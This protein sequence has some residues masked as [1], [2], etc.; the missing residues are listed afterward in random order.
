MSAATKTKRKR[1]KF[2]SIGLDLSLT[3]S[4]VVVLVD[5]KVEYTSTITSKPNGDGYYGEIARLLD[6]VS[7]IS[8]V[9]YKYAPSIV[10]IEGIAFMAKNTTALVQLSALNYFLRRELFFSGIPFIIVAPPTL[11]KFATGK[12]NAT[13]VE[14][15]DSVEELYGEKFLDDNQA[16]AYVLARCA[17]LAA[18]GGS[19]IYDFQHD[20]INMLKSQVNT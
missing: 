17:E 7:R 11:K 13:K 15:M 8:S 2:T 20:T 6:I 9:V 10:A 16:D 19:K 14:V 5:G 18:G 12:G 3:S 1:S 4:G